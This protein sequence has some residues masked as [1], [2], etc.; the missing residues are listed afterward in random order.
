MIGDYL[1]IAP[2]T[3]PDVPAVPVWVDTRTGN[4]DPFI[5]RV[6]IAPEV[7]FTS[8]Q[9]SRLSLAQ[10]DNPDLGGTGGDADGDGENN[11][12]NFFPGPSLT[13]PPR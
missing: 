5:T 4:P 2:T 13:I 3:E 12:S 6:G 1:G 9:A 11:L 7:D 10:I 8:F